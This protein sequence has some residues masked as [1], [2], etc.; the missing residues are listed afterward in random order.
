MTGNE[1]KPTGKSMFLANQSDFEDLVLEEEDA[2]DVTEEALA[3]GEEGKEEVK[4][5][6]SDEE[7]G[8]FVY[9][10]ALYDADGMDEED[11]DFDD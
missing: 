8:G 10:R 6:D 1:D 2:E 4:D 7:E 5:D 3:A 11:V 9:D